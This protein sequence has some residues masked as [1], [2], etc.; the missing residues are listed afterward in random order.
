MITKENL[1]DWLNQSA[2][3]AY[4]K[5]LESYI[6]RVIKK[7]ALAG[8]VSFYISTGKHTT[9]RSVKTEFY[10]IWNTDKLSS[11]NRR[12]VQDEVIEK[13]RNFGFDLERAMIDC[14]WDNHYFALLFNDIDKVVEEQP[15]GKK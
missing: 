6:D 4:A 3:D 5:E 13:Y 14:G 12:I 15:K 8:E 1:K 7:N 11:N 9:A 2:R 10:D